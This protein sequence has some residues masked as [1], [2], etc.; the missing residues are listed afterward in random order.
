MTTPYDNQPTD[1]PP[2][3]NPESLSHLP[4]LEDYSEQL[5]AL[6]GPAPM[7]NSEMRDM[8]DMVKATHTMILELRD[9]VDDLPAQLPALMGTLPPMVRLMLGI[10]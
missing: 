8:Y 5:Y 2:L 4:T 3:R 6:L 10:K 9:I 7:T 1:L